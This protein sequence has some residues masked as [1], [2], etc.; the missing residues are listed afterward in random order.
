PV[1]K[2]IRVAHYQRNMEHD[3][4]VIAHSCGVASPRQLKRF[5]ARRVTEQGYS[6]PLDQLYPDVQPVEVLQATGG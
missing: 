1:E 6:I 4:G 2:A 3:V 5:H